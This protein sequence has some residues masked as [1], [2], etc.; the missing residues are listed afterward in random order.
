MDWN[1]IKGGRVWNI[2][3][4]CNERM[5]SLYVQVYGVVVLVQL[6]MNQ[7]KFLSVQ[8]SE[9]IIEKDKMN[10]FLVVTGVL[11]HIEIPRA[12][13]D[14][15]LDCEHLINMAQSTLSLCPSGD[16]SLLLL[17]KHRSIY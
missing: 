6:R 3:D 12:F 13:E 10:Q 7:R 2:L 9:D 4:H 8:L 15:V 11:Y 14:S 16:S 5:V 17:S 1:S